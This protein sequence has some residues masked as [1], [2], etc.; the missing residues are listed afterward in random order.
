VIIGNKFIDGSISADLPMQ[1]VSELFNV[2]SFIVSQTNPF[3][4][5]FMDYEDGKSILGNKNISFWSLCK[6]LIGSE[7]KMRI[8]QVFPNLSSLILYI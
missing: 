8:S 5:P 2:N 3:A 1:R 6:N 7:I 4:I